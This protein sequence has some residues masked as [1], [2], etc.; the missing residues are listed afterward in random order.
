MGADA[1]KADAQLKVRDQAELCN[2][3]CCPG[4]IRRTWFA[5]TRTHANVF[6]WFHISNKRSSFFVFRRQSCDVFGMGTCVA[7]KQRDVRTSVPSAAE[8][9]RGM[10]P[11]VRTGLEEPNS[12]QTL[13]FLNVG[14]PACLLVCEKKCCLK[15]CTKSLHPPFLRCHPP[16]SCGELK[17]LD[18]FVDARIR[19]KTKT[20]LF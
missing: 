5:V 14:L 8:E 12:G 4:M 15:E 9:L 10:Q 19:K 18:F 3:L 11:V 17:N 16:F 2:M 6:R 1:N 7:Q 20:S 13:H